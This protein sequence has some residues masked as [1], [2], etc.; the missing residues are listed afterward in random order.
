MS[1]HQEAL[2][3][4]SDAFKADDARARE[5]DLYRL[6]RGWTETAPATSRI[7]WP[8]PWRLAAAL[9]LGALLADGLLRGRRPA[10][11]AGAVPPTTAG[12]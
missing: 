1:G 7:T 6:G 3:Q 9:A 5:T 10:R 2:G 4:P 11:R 8:A 12:P